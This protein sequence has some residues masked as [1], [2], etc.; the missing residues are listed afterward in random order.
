MATV[1]Q[2]AVI[3]NW[4][5]Q[6]EPPHLKTIQDRIVHNPRAGQLL[7]LYQE[8]LTHNGVAQD[9]S[10]KQVALRLTGLVV[11]QGNQLQVY[12][13]IYQA[14]FDHEWIKD[15]F[16]SIRPYG[17]QLEAWA[18]TPNDDALLLQGEDLDQALA[19]A[20]E[21]SLGKQDY[22]FLVESQK[23]GLKT[24]LATMR[25]TVHRTN[26]QLSRKTES[27]E[28]VDSELERV[29]TELTNAKTELEQAHTALNQ[30]RN[31]LQTVRKRTRW[32]SGL[33][34]GLV[35]LAMFGAIWFGKDAAQSAKAVSRIATEIDHIPKRISKI[36]ERS[37]GSEV[38]RKVLWR[39]R[40]GL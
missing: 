7:G 24:E 30:S 26:Q 36:H 1:V 20:E 6:D 4:T 15:T 11:E 28:R 32:T 34:I 10:A 21:R 14:V 39:R 33:G 9:G 38:R 25:D 17:H 5:I 16:V 40:K 12:N 37:C 29:N 23:L 35:S 22:Q 8:V 3:D 27:L 18:A 31:E 19:W 2:T 13:P